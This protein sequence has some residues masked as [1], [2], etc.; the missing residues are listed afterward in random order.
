MVNEST[1]IMTPEFIHKRITEQLE[2]ILSIISDTM[3][4]AERKNEILVSACGQL[5]YFRSLKRGKVSVRSLGT[6]AIIGSGV[7]AQ[8]TLIREVFSNKEEIG[9]VLLVDSMDD[10][11]R[12]KKELYDIPEPPP[13]KIT[14]GTLLTEGSSLI[15][16]QHCDFTEKSK[17]DNFTGSPIGAI[18]NKNKRKRDYGRGNGRR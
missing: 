16:I 17:K 7:D 15:P 12:L 11:P 5:E 1:F 3:L 4:T 13:L 14:A 18:G 8:S 10:L 6:L 9:R 2:Y